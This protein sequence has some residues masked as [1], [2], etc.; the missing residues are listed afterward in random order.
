MLGFAWF[1]SSESGLFNGLR[2]IQTR[3]IWVSFSPCAK[4]LKRIFCYH[5]SLRLDDGKPGLDPASSKTYSTVFSFSQIIGRKIAGRI[6]S[7]GEA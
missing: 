7:R 1:Y 6:L 2:R 3:K 5:F 4:L